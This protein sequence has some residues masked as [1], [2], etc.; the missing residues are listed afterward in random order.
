MCLIDK[1][2]VQIK[3][4]G[5]VHDAAITLQRLLISPGPFVMCL[6]CRRHPLLHPLHKILSIIQARRPEDDLHIAAYLD[7]SKEEPN[8]ARV[9]MRTSALRILELLACPQASSSEAAQD[10]TSIDEPAAQTL[11]DHP[12]SQEQNGPL[13]AFLVSMLLKA[14]ETE[15]TGRPPLLASLQCLFL[16]WMRDRRGAQLRLPAAKPQLKAA[17]LHA[18]GC[19]LP[20]SICVVSTR[21]CRI[22]GAQAMRILTAPP[23]SAYVRPSL[24]KLGPAVKPRL[25]GIH[26]MGLIKIHIC[27]RCLRRLQ[28]AAAQCVLLL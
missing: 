11:V 6:A 13:L 10:Q 27:S 12:I 15:L 21:S 14:A 1:A 8:S 7:T 25:Y 20:V 2:T 9:Q 17:V 16:H 24:Q 19:M 23:C 5:S 26:M 28:E 3:T 4:T 22:S 18:A